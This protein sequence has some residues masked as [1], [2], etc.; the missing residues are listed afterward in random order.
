MATPRGS[1]MEHDGLRSFADRW[2]LTLDGPVLDTPSSR[3]A[4]GCRNGSPV[5]LKVAKRSFP[6]RCCSARARCSANSPP[7]RAIANCCTAIFTVWA[8]DDGTDPARA[9]WRR[10]PQYG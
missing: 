1:A 2:N 4:F 9:E 7:R 8:L 5:V 6:V 10:Q 3:V